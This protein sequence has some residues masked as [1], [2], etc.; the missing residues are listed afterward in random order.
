LLFADGLA[1][2]SIDLGSEFM[3]VAIVKPGV[4]MEIALN[5][6][7]MWL[8]IIKSL[9]ICC[10]IHRESRRKTHVTVSFRNGE[11]MIGEPARNAG[12]K[13]PASAYWFFGD[14]LGRTID[15]PQ[16]KKFLEKFPYYNIE[17]HPDNN[18]LV[19]KHDE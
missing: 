1:V 17:G 4:P 5:E 9:L 6:C 13:R 2:M 14:L 16:V 7:V 11:R 18:L 15:N 12:L 8:I 19:F 3:K 10:F